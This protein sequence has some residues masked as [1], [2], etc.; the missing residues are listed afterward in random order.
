MVKVINLFWHK[1]GWATFWALL[2]LHI[3]PGHPAP[4][5]GLPIYRHIFSQDPVSVVG[6]H[7]IETSRGGFVW[8]YVHLTGATI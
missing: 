6:I 3:S 7:G 2:S 4:F 1:M 5:A 8:A